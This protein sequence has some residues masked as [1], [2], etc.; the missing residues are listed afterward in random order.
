[1]KKYLPVIIPLL[2]VKLA[3]HLVGNANYGFH[4]DEL[5]HLSAGEHLATGYME[6]PPFIAFAG[7]LSHLLFGYDLSGMRIFATLAGLGILWL[8]CR[9]AMEMG[10]KKMAVLIAGISILAFLPYYRNH[11]LF[12]PV[13]F[14]QFFWTLGFFFLIRYINTG[15][16]RY[17]VLLGLTAGL[18]V[19]NKYT[20]LL[21]VGGAL[22]GLLFHR[23]GNTFKNKWLYL[24]GALALLIVLPNFIWQWQHN[25]PLVLHVKRLDEL[26]APNTF[27]R[28]QLR[29]P[30]TLLLSLVGLFALFFHQQLRKYRSVAVA[31]LF[32]FFMLWLLNSKGYYFFAAYPVLFAAG[33]VQVE[34]WLARRPAWNYGVAAFLLLPVMPFV[35]DAIPILPVKTFVEYKQLQPDA[36]GRYQLTS[37]YADMFGWEEQVRLVDSLYA[38]LSAKE[39]AE[40]VLWASNYGEA[41]AIKILGGKEP[42]CRH[43]SFWLW[44]PGR[45]SG[46]IA[47]SIGNSKEVVDKVYE[48]AQ[49][50]KTIRHPYAIDEEN[51]IGLYLCRGPR[52]SLP[53]IWP[54][55]A[56]QVFE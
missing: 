12:Q 56:N 18:G 46:R 8:C 17:L 5:L 50:V 13:A 43:G 32:I 22:T 15:E 30:F 39:Q 26:S 41:G 25:F 54:T 51:N 3:V 37:D 27:A 2:L 10:G 24:A 45:K 20:M 38:S 6:F 33:A 49:L 48:Q 28:D 35:P 19:M 7:R 4:R 34:Q 1:M 53:I 55:L 14:D 11:L 44:G 29:L 47:I 31:V 16:P 23:Q 36:E 52:I 9:M 40:C 42:L 21:W